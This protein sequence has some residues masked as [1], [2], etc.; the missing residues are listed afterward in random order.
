[1]GSSQVAPL[2][3]QY[4]FG[5]HA[6]Q[7]IDAGEWLHY[8]PHP[9][10]KS[11]SV[12]ISQSGESAEIRHLI[13][14]DCAIKPIVAITNN[15]AS[16][17]ADT[18]DLLLPLCAG[19]EKSITTKTYS[20][21]L[22]LLYLLSADDRHRALTELELVS[23][24]LFD[25]AQDQIKRAASILQ[26]SVHIAFVGRGPAYAS[27]CQCAL[28]FTEGTR[29]PTNAFSGGAFRHGPL[30]ATGNDFPVVFLLPTGT[31]YNLTLQ[32][33]LETADFGSSVVVFTDNDE[34]MPQ[35]T[36]TVIKVPRFENGD[37]ESLFPLL[38]SVAHAMLLDA[39]AT[40]RGIETGEF[41]HIEKVTTRE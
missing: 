7:I 16:Y 31:T 12:F 15:E 24:I 5:K 18:A 4:R 36:L 28:T 2:A 35:D 41:R 20:N 13:K 23:G 10:R 25:I 32:L 26:D 1:M 37:T 8:Q 17:L 6:C 11:L 40:A 9:P 34:L 29:L 27:A 3:A 21:T 33:A 39:V 22:A 19:K 38:S 30:E 14:S